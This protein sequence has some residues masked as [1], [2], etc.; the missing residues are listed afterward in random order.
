MLADTRRGRALDERIALR[1]LAGPH[2]ARLRVVGEHGG[3]ARD[4]QVVSFLL[5]EAPHGENDP[6]RIRK[7]QRRAQPGPRRRAGAV[8]WVRDHA[9][10]VV[11]DAYRVL[12]PPER[13]GEDALV[14]L[15]HGHPH[16]SPAAGE[17][18]D[19]AALAAEGD[20]GRDEMRDGDG[21]RA[22]DREREH[23]AGRDIGMR[24][25]DHR[26]APAAARQCPGGHDEVPHEPA[27]GLPE[28][29]R[30]LEPDVEATAVR[31]GRRRSS[32]TLAIVGQ[33][34]SIV[35]TE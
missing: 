29:A 28:A 12:A 14:V 10:A 17:L 23:G 11:D 5:V 18:V 7:P 19:E 16:L 22:T 2:P 21:P 8:V 27:S 6:V 9:D 3:H 25:H 35:M 24:Q 32:R 33:S 30:T 26:R 1:P 15:R 34:G 31:A 13:V 20:G 4:D